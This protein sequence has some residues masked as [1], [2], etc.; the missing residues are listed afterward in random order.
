M[1]HY[2]ALLGELAFTMRE[3]ADNAADDTAQTTWTQAA[4]MLDGALAADAVMTPSKSATGQPAKWRKLIAI[5]HRT[6]NN[7]AAEVAEAA[8]EAHDDPATQQH[9]DRTEDHLRRAA[10]RTN[11]AV[12]SLNEIDGPFA[13][14]AA[15]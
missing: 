14:R 6:V 5:A 1:S 13:K 2:R 4:D 15:S 3:N 9:L 8:A 11:S 12:I 10:R 7:V